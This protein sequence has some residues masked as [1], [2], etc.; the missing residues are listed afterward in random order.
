MTDDDQAERVRAVARA[1]ETLEPDTTPAASD[2]PPAAPP[3]A[4][5]LIRCPV[6]EG[7]GEEL[8]GSGEERLCRCADCEVLFCNPRPSIGKVREHRRARFASALGK[9]H[10]AR[11]RSDRLM[12]LE[13]MKGYHGLVSGR[14]APLN[15]FDRRVLD[16]GCAL[17]FRLREFEKY[18]WSVLGTETA[19]GALAYARSTMLEVLEQDLDDVPAS[20]GPFHLVVLD[21]VIGEAADPRGLA[22]TLL[23]HLAPKGVI[24]VCVPESE[25]GGPSLPEGAIYGFSEEA[26]RR[27]FMGCGAGQPQVAR[28]DGRL[29]MWFQRKREDR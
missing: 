28:L 19:A 25:T 1:R 21:E 14:P 7:H 18:G 5:R 10:V 29:I 4:G 16:I 3:P 9:A 24:C 12:A 6:C 23:M 13:A 2:A 22:A 8:P 17:G 11:Q 27:L 26:L 20:R 15:A